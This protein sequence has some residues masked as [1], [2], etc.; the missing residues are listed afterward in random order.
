MIDLPENLSLTFYLMAS[1]KKDRVKTT[2]W[3]ERIYLDI[4]KDEGICISDT[5]NFLLEQYLKQRGKLN[6]KEVIE[7]LK[8][9]K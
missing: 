1:G 2:V 6:V 3:I 4:L 9:R 5:V 8:T 7:S